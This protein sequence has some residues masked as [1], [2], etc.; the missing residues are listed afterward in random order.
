MFQGVGL[1]HV[2][3]PKENFYEMFFIMKVSLLIQRNH[4]LYCYIEILRCCLSLEN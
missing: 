4:Q 1:E 3:C 2:I